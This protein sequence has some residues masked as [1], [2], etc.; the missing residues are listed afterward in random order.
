MP[1]AIDA[2]ANACDAM[3]GAACSPIE[4]SVCI[5][6]WNNKELLRRCLSSLLHSPQGVDLEVIVADNASTDGASE[7]V[8]REFPQVVLIQNVENRGF[9]IASNQA[10][11]CARGSYLFFLN[12]DTEVPPLS[13]RRL[14]NHAAANPAGG[15]FGPRMRQPDG[16]IQ[17][18][19]RRRPTIAALLHKISLVRWTGLFRRAYVDYRRESFVPYGVRNVEVLL[20]SAVLLPREVFATI[21]GWDERYR[22][23]VEDIDLATQVGRSRAVVFAGDVEI[24]HHGRVSSRENVRFVAPNVA[25]GYVQFFRKM[26][27]SGER[28]F[29]YKLLVTLDAPLQL[30]GKVLA[31]GIRYAVGQRQTGRRR[32]AAARG[33]WAFLRHELRRFWKA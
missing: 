31:G 10:A 9:A 27:V 24:I 17:I 15:M 14:L 2:P 6:N 19:Y 16:G 33:L 28:L 18:S 5:A 13:L 32:W 1:K 29:C 25:T 7:M 21:G 23:G 3:S 22:F 12:N 26:G 30:V 20:G 8:A 4:V 11:D